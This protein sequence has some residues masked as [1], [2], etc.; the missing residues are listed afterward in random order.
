[1]DS[2][3]EHLR[4][5]SIFHYIVAGLTACM[6]CIP[7][8]H[9]AMGILVLT[10]P[11]VLNGIGNQPRPPRAFAELFGLLM[12]VIPGMMIV[13]G[14]IFAIC[15]FF[16]ARF[17][18][19]RTHYFFCLVIAGISCLVFPFGTVLG[20]FT[21]IVLARPSV[22]TLFLQPKPYEQ[23]NVGPFQR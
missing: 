5:L 21:L 17:L 13:L 19:R 20:V 3:Q 6:A 16:A 10:Q 23:S 9:L 1:M 22:K 11:D 7:I 4:L 15:L 2:D 14:W 12:I 8:F 18:G